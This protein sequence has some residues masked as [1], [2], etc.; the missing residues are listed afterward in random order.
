MGIAKAALEASV[1]YLA[2]EL[3]KKNIRV[4]AISAGAIRTVA[5]MSI[6]GFRK[7]VAKYNATAPLGRMITH[8][9]VGNLGLYLL[10][11]YPAAPPARRCM[12][13]QATASW[14]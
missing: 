6:P 1:R 9:E 13:M 5:A 2:Y 4:N 8:E 14:A 10:S 11:P 3:G 7:M 12:W